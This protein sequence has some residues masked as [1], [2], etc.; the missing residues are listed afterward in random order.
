[1]LVESG[2]IEKGPLRS[3]TGRKIRPYIKSIFGSVG[4]R[5][6]GF[7]LSLAARLECALVVFY[8]K[9]EQCPR[10]VGHVLYDVSTSAVKRSRNELPKSL[11]RSSRWLFEI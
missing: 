11:A 3:G 1:M 6:H 2:F 9:I 5:N 8:T 7:V 4:C 10:I